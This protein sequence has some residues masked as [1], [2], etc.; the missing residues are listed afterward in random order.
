VCHDLLKPDSDLVERAR[1]VLDCSDHF[2]K[3]DTDSH[4]RAREGEEATEEED[5]TASKSAAKRAKTNNQHRGGHSVPS[6]DADEALGDGAAS[7]SD[8]ST[9]EDFGL[10]FGEDQDDDLLA[11]ADAEARKT[12][13]AED[14]LAVEL[15]VDDHDRHARS[16]NARSAAGWCSA[17]TSSGLP[18]S[19]SSSSTTR[20][21]A[22]PSSA[23][24][25][26]VV[27]LY[28]RLK[29]AG[30]AGG[31]T[32]L[33]LL[34]V[35]TRQALGYKDLQNRDTPQGQSVLIWRRKGR[36][37]KA[38]PP[39]CMSKP[40]RICSRID[41][42]AAMSRNHWQNLLRPSFE[43]LTIFFFVRSVQSRR[44]PVSQ[45]ATLVVWALHLLPFL[46]LPLRALF[47]VRV[48]PVKH[49]FRQHSY[50]IER[51][52][53]AKTK[54][55]AQCCASQTS[56]SRRRPFLQLLQTADRSRIP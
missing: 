46:H 18:S 27:S 48:C 26:A 4:K 49:H 53:V 15:A 7:V 41:A 22:F 5:G 8:D 14:Q 25:Q 31:A 9:A 51:H 40:T 44:A 2:P 13:D 45:T 28:L 32:L 42:G 39:W 56:A 16:E 24:I 34:Q 52:H 38:L 30:R 47:L 43:S 20:S 3:L 54:Q 36:T 19:S 17:S 21:T 35:R 50:S 29:Q 23:E 12:D 37:M 55:S 11:D 33:S 10:D 6:L 1:Q